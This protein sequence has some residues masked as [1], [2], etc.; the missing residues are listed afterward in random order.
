MINDLKS[1]MNEYQLRGEDGEEEET[2]KENIERPK[3]AIESVADL[4]KEIK[5]DSAQKKKR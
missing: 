4:L 5:I 1:K 3:D 2:K